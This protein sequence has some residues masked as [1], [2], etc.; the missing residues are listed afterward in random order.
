[1]AIVAALRTRGCGG[2]TRYGADSAADSRTDTGATS[3]S[4][5]RANNRPGTGAN[6]ATAQ[7]TVGGIIRI[8][9]RGRRQN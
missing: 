3:A 8:R 1:M 9:E 5:D 6:Q 4:C 2:S 7:R